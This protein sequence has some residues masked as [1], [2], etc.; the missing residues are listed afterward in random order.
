LHETIRRRGRE[1]RGLD[2]EGSAC[3]ARESRS[4]A[5][6]KEGVIAEALTHFQFIYKI[7]PQGKNVKDI[8]FLMADCYSGMGSA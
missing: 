8:A 2:N 5:L 4:L 1:V 7:D 6:E 3:S